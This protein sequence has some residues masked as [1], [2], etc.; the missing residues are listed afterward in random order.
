M[1]DYRRNRVL[2][3]TYFFTVTLR[4]RSA[5]TLIDHVEVLRESVKTVRIRWPFT[6]DAMVVLPN[7]LHALWTLPKGDTDYST[8]WR[9]IKSGFSRSLPASTPRRVWQDRFW[10]HT[11]RDDDDYRHHVE[12]IWFNPVKHGHVERVGNWPHSSFHR[13]VRQ[14]LVAADWGGSVSVEQESGYGE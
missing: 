14:G 11:I 10:E 2:G 9:L 12:Y 4:D 1:V 7:H 8:R 13:A 3:G 5:R 6:I